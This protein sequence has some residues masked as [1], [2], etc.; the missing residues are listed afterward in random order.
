MPDGT[1]KGSRASLPVKIC[2]DQVQALYPLAKILQLVLVI[3]FVDVPPLVG[4]QAVR[5][6]TNLKA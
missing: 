1:F 2:S 6:C 5:Y 3:F 4:L